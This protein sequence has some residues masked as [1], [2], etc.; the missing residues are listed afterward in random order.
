[1]NRIFNAHSFYVNKMMVQDTYNIQRF[2]W[3]IYFARNMNVMQ[4][5]RLNKIRNCIP[6]SLFHFAFSFEI[7]KIL[8]VPP[9]SYTYL[10]V[11]I[12]NL[13]GKKRTHPFNSHYLSSCMGKYE[14]TVR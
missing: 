7:E 10:R 9:T 14:Y 11:Y 8:F 2:F 3:K 1:M 6:F 13:N 5:V 4:I 12:I